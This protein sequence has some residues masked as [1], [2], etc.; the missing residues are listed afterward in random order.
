MLPS[1][2]NPR[3]IITKAW[4]PAGPAEQ[5]RVHCN[6]AHPNRTLRRCIHRQQRR[7]QQQ[8]AALL[9]ASAHTY[10]YDTASSVRPVLLALCQMCPRCYML[11]LCLTQHIGHGHVAFAV[12][13][14][15]RPPAQ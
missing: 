5:C 9:G 14:A 6:D 8:R 11:A 7:Q 1:Q 4:L 13:G 10:A 2:A 12:T 3:R 15:L